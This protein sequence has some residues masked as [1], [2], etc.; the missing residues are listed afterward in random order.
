[1]TTRSPGMPSVST[2]WRI[3]SSVK[4]AWRDAAKRSRA[5]RAFVA[6][7]DEHQAVELGEAGGTCQIANQQ[8]SAWPRPLFHRSKRFGRLGNVMND[9]VRH[10]RLKLR[11]PH[12]FVQAA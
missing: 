3:S 5:A 6:G 2:I 10:H 4:A 9:R 7:V 1:M 8:R 11:L 12:S